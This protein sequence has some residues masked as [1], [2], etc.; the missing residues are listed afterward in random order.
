VVARRPDH[1]LG[2]EDDLAVAVV[3]ARGDLLEQQLGRGGASALRGWRTDDS[4]TAAA[5]AKTMSS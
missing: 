1:Q 2:L 4:G 3:A 5:E